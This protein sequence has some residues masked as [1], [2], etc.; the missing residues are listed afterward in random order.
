[1]HLADEVDESLPRFGHTLLWPVGKLELP[2]CPGLT[3]LQTHK[4]ELI[5]NVWKQKEGG[6]QRE[7]FEELLM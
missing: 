4:T 7:A 6:D 3:V 2:Y 5:N 1:M